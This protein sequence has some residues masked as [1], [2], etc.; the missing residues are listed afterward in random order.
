[1][2]M[3]REIYDKAPSLERRLLFRE[4]GVARFWP[5]GMSQHDG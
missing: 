1:M 5:L 3:L 4:G 2:T